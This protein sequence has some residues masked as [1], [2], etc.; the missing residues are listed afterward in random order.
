MRIYK[1]LFAAALTL[2]LAL[3]PGASRAQESSLGTYSPYSMYGLGNLTGSP[4][5]AFAG[6]GGTSIG[7]RNGG[8]DTTADLR[9]NLSNAASLSGIPGQTFIFDVGL[10]GSNVYAQQ[11]SREGMLRTSFNTFNF[12]NFS[13]AFPLIGNKMGFAVSVSPFSEV[14]YKIHND[15]ESHLSDL[16]VVRYFYDGQGNVTEAKAALGL[17]LLRNL[18]IGVEANYLWGNIDRMYKAEILNYLVSGTFNSINASTNERVG[19]IFAAFGMQYTPL[20]KARTRL[21][22][23]ATYRLGGKLDSK[24]T[25]YIPSNNIFEDVIRLDEYTSPT[26]M[27]D[28]IGA[29]VYFHRPRW[30]VGADYVYEGWGKHNEYDALNDVRYVNTNTFKIGA[31][32]TPNRYDIRGK[33]GSFFN[34][35]TYK[36]GFRTGANYLEFR[37][38]PMNERAVSFGVDIPFKATTVSN[39]SIGIEYSERGRLGTVGTPGGDLVKERY[40]KINA[41]VMLFGGDY[42]YWFRKYKYN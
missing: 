23:G 26:Y 18:S 13:I 28:R 21:T 15:D 16:G 17:Q 34:R 40:F 38:V 32:Y 14:G 25:D 29:G 36:A 30:A 3:T 11:R 7:F 35:M 41:G 27:P 24:V 19:K 9:L 4:L 20:D 10:A 5:S 39:L 37:G 22:I 42:D 8:F 1:Y 2:G 31:R 12:N 6:M 33:F